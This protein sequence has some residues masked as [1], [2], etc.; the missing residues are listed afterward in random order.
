MFLAFFC[1]RM[2]FPGLGATSIFFKIPT[3][4]ISFWVRSLG[5]ISRHLTLFKRWPQIV[6]PSGG[7]ENIMRLCLEENGNINE[8]SSL[9]MFL[10]ATTRI[11]GSKL[12]IFHLFDIFPV[13]VLLLSESRNKKAAEPN[14]PLQCTQN[15]FVYSSVA[16]F[17]FISFLKRFLQLLFNYMRLFFIYWTNCLLF[18]DVLSS[19]ALSLGLSF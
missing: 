17:N 5:P 4:E 7:P 12:L 19:C 16:E 3:P 14:E 2:T 10:A 11:M 13:P 15:V 9:M 18:I 1:R 8:C 6:V